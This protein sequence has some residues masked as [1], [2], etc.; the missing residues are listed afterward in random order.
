LNGE[1]RAIARCFF[2]GPG[3]CLRPGAELA[4]FPDDD[5]MNN[6]ITALVVD[7][8]TILFDG[9]TL[10]GKDEV[11][12]VLRSALERDPNFILVIRSTSTGHYKGI[13][14]LIYTSQ[15]VGVS[16]EKLRWQ[17]DD[18]EIVSLD[19][20]RARNPTPPI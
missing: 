2:Y 12:D 11:A 5:T 18:G 15:R 16:V 6:Q 10:T 7:D 1:Q 20:L 9:R 14:T 8:E 3:F 4:L 17:M 19:E 13:G